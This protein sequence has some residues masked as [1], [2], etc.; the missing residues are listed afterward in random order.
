MASSTPSATP[1]PA[2][3][4]ALR[5]HPKYIFF[6]DFD[7][8]ITN[9]DSNDWMFLHLGL[10]RERRDQAFDDVLQ[11]RTTFRQMF[12]EQMDAI[13]LPFD[14]CLDLLRDAITLDAGFV[15]FLTWAR[16]ENVPVVVLSGG[17]EPTV[18]G[19]L[20]HLLGDEMLAGLPIVGN[21]QGVREGHQSVNEERGWEVV[22]RDER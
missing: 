6:T 17:M 8:T 11:G 4:P 20:G 21:F 9:E 3:L 2:L 12:K 14:R 16:R 15:D 10:G 18:R 5:T 1:D 7:G 22:Y 13:A 19:L